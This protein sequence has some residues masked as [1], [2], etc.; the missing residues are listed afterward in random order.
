[1]ESHE[2]E[3]GVKIPDKWDTCVITGLPWGIKL[4]AIANYLANYVVGFGVTVGVYREEQKIVL[5]NGSPFISFF[6]R[7]YFKTLTSQDNYPEV[8]VS[9]LPKGPD[10]PPEIGLKGRIRKFLRL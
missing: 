3:Q 4:D 5:E 10:Q 6:L 2:A 7:D 9:F 8:Q 1:M